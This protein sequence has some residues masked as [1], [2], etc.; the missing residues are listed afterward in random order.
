MIR[1]PKKK[2]KVKKSVI[3]KQIEDGET[4]NLFQEPIAKQEAKILFGPEVKTQPELFKHIYQLFEKDNN[5]RYIFNTK[6]TAENMYLNKNPK[7]FR[8]TNLTQNIKGEPNFKTYK[9]IYEHLNLNGNK[10]L[11]VRDDEDNIKKLSINALYDV[12]II[13]CELKIVI[14]DLLII[15]EPKITMTKINTLKQIL[16]IPLNN[17]ITPNQIYQII[18]L[19][20]RGN[21]DYEGYLNPFGTIGELNATFYINVRN[22]ANNNSK[23]LLLKKDGENYYLYYNVRNYP[24]MN[25]ILSKLSINIE[26][27][28]GSNCVIETLKYIYNHPNDFLRKQGNKKIFKKE[29]DKMEN[30]YLK[31][32]E[33]PSYKILVDFLETTQTNY[34]VFNYTNKDDYNFNIFNPKQR[35]FNFIVYNEHL[36]LIDNDIEYNKIKNSLD[37]NDKYLILDK[38]NFNNGFNELLRTL[39]NK[40]PTYEIIKAKKEFGTMDAE[41]LSYKNNDIVYIKDDDA[42]TNSNLLYFCQMFNINYHPYISEGNIIDKILTDNNIRQTKSFYL[43]NHSS[44]DIIYSEELK[45]LELYPEN[46]ITFDFNKFYSNILLSLDKIPIVNN[47]IHKTEIYNGEEIDDNYF[48]SIKILDNNYNLWFKNDEMFFGK[49]LNSPYYKPI[50]SKMLKENKIK[51]VDKIKCE[52]IDNYYI[53]I[54]KKLFEFVELT[55]NKNNIVSTVK[56]IINKTIGKFQLGKPEIKEIYKYHI[57]ENNK[58]INFHHEEN[59]NYY[60]YNNGNTSYKLFYNLEEKKNNYFNVLENHRPLRTLIINMSWLNMLKF[61]VDN[62][63]DEKDI[64][65]IN[66]DSL[67]IRNKKNK[68]LTQ[69]EL[70]EEEKLFE[71]LN[72]SY[73]TKPK[74]NKTTIQKINK[75]DE[76]Y[77]NGKYNNLIDEIKKE[78]ETNKYNL[79]GIKIQE[80]K[81]YNETL[82]ITPNN[83]SFIDDIQKHNNKF[84]VNLGYAGSGKS[85]K[86][87]NLIKQFKQN[88]QSYILL[89]PLLKVL[90]LFNITE[91]NI[92]D[93]IINNG[94]NFLYD[95]NINK[96]TFQHFT[97]N[98]KVP[99]EDNIIIDEFY[100]INC[101]DMRYIINW[102]YTHNKNIYLY[103]DIYQ[104]PPILKNYNKPLTSQNN[105]EEENEEENEEIETETQ[106]EKLK[107]NIEFLKSIS[108]EYNYYLDTDENKR[109]NFNFD[110]YEEFIKNEYTEKEQINLINHFI[111][112]RCDTTKKYINICY[113]NDTKNKINDEYLLKNNQEFNKNKISG[114]NIPLIAKKNYKVN[115]DII[116]C[117]KEEFNLNVNKNKYILSTEDENNKLITFEMEPDKIFKLFSVAYCLN[118]YNIQGQTLTNFKFILD[119]VYFLNNNNKYNICG[120]F[121]TLISR[122]KEPLTEKKITI[123]DI[124]EIKRGIK[125][126]TQVINNNVFITK[127]NEYKF[128][129]KNEKPKPK[130]RNNTDIIINIQ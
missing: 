90:Q 130:R 25:N 76:I 89:A 19:F 73:L 44:A 49:V 116:I 111:N 64:Y 86:I 72:N 108:T 117:A 105:N 28:E 81:K 68:P 15:R 56:N 75:N 21:D 80:Y 41:I 53:P 125:N 59:E 60:N 74:K 36:N 127:N 118:L 107:L 5:G 103:G 32:N 65:Q 29:L 11:L 40:L 48:Y 47:L 129:K 97:R 55:E 63:I 58:V 77:Y 83:I 104:L 30:K 62:K 101:D 121:Y 45:E 14:S 6:A 112:N 43:Y 95:T 12:N 87:N 16:N 51:I 4:Y 38:T 18:S 50:L 10:N 88:K 1:I 120:A 124:Q 13:D 20:L 57:E 66:T 46:F 24:E 42:K 94:L 54:I 102:L 123:G 109:N 33:I 93:N 8:K 82:N 115:E 26:F 35:T 17:K 3:K 99:E 67:T 100:L 85:Y 34:N 79:Y 98:L 31:N 39:K 126:N 2:L 96:K 69:E 128:G 9:P 78:Q 84:V 37:T 119:D 70:E 110:V 91:E 71:E 61:V 7:S 52:W 106:N 113:R 27:P 22:T 122:I 23:K 92:N 114:S